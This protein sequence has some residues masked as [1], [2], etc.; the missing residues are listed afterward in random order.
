MIS[1]NLDSISASPQ[2]WMMMKNPTQSQSLTSHF[3]FLLFLA[4]L[5]N[6]MFWCW[7]SGEL[8]NGA[9]FHWIG[10][11]V[12]ATIFGSLLLVAD[13]VWYYLKAIGKVAMGGEFDMT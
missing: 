10:N 6:F 5:M 11:L 1:L 9:H 3:V 8:H 7:S 4:R 13:F 12:L 2:V